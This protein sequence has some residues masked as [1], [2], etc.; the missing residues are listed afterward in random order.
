LQESVHWVTGC[1]FCRNSFSYVTLALRKRERQSR[2]K[3]GKQAIRFFG[4][5]N[6]WPGIFFMTLLS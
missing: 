4:S 1:H 3:S 2:I 5:R 6:S